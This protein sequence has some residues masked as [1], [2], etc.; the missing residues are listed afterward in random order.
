MGGQD[1]QVGHLGR[2]RSVGFGQGRRDARV[3]QGVDR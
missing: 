2:H 1:H 3:E